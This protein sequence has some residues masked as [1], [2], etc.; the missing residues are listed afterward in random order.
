MQ[1]TTRITENIQ[2]GIRKLAEAIP[3]I[4]NDELHAGLEGATKEARGGWPD[5]GV[6]GYNV[7]LRPEQ[8]YGRTGGLGAASSWHI[9]G[10]SYRFE[11]NAYSVRGEPYSVGVLGDGTGQGQWA[12]HQGRWPV[13]FQV[14]QKWAKSM[15]SNMKQKF[16]AVV[17]SIG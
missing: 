5:G 11:S 4:T 12:V 3:E 8:K 15:L 9:E 10:K 1:I 17:K 6:Q 13:A 2:L 7:P 16:D 14:M